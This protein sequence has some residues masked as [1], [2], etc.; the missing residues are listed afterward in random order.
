MTDQ[1]AQ[2]VDDIA[3]CVD[4]ILNMRDHLA[5]GQYAGHAAPVVA[6][7]KDIQARLTTLEAGGGAGPTSAEIAKAV[8]DDVAARMAG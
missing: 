4:A 2:Q 6:A 1:T 3:W 5:G 7:I 8:N